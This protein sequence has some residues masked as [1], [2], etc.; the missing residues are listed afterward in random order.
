M[1]ALQWVE[2][3]AGWQWWVFVLLCM[4]IGF[5]VG[6]LFRGLVDREREEWEREIAEAVR[7]RRAAAIHQFEIE[8]AKRRHPSR[9]AAP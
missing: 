8:R 4:G 9:R 2:G 6:W 7:A 1:T 3:A 5:V